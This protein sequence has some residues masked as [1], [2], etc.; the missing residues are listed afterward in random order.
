MPRMIVKLIFAL[1]LF[2]PAVKAD[3]IV[4]SGSVTFVPGVSGFGIRVEPFTLT[5]TGFS[6]NI[7]QVT[8]PLGLGSCSAGLNPPCTVA[9]LG[10]TSIGTDNHGSFTINGV[11]K[12]ADV[13]NQISFF[14]SS[15]DVAIPPELLNAPGIVITAPFSFTGAGQFLSG[16]SVSLTGQG[17][18]TA[19]LIRRDAGF[20]P[21]L[22]FQNAVYV[23]GPVVEEVT[24][25]AIPEPAT[26]VLLVSSL[27]GAGV[28]R[29]WRN[30]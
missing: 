11:T 4:V 23:F 5:G 15:F 9:H 30:R 18:V 19:L 27:A 6:A 16:E 10:W 2:V 25:Q 29:R 24:V 8:A 13:I 20:G 28:W 26:L 22:Y 12:P 21:G 3:P 1:V 7:T 14:F 17:T